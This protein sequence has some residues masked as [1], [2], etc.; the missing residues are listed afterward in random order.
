[1]PNG[2]DILIRTTADDATGQLLLEIKDTG[3]GIPDNVKAK[4]FD[5]FFTTKPIGKGTGL[6]LSIVSGI[7]RAHC[8][9]I[10]VESTAGQGTT[11]KLYFPL[12]LAS[13]E[14]ELKPGAKT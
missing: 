8:G 2:G 4:I 11:L 5:P 7:M 13:G 3:S 6:G 12:T 9:E 10:V 1:M 14:L